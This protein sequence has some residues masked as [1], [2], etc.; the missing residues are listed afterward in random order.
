[1]VWERRQ[2]PWNE[3]GTTHGERIV[4]DAQKV[5]NI[6]KELLQD[7]NEH[8]LPD[9][10]DPRWMY[11]LCQWK[12]FWVRYF[13]NL[14]QLRESGATEPWLDAYHKSAYLAMARAGLVKSD[15]IEDVRTWERDS[16]IRFVVYK[17]AIENPPPWPITAT[18]GW[19]FARFLFPSEE[20]N[21]KLVMLMNVEGSGEIQALDKMVDSL[22]KSYGH[23]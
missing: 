23:C 19:E 3:I 2:V 11:E 4:V 1:V 7:L 8:G 5:T 20:P 12:M 10:S 9:F 15:N 13:A 21:W 14:P 22:E 6:L 17:R 16:D 18:R